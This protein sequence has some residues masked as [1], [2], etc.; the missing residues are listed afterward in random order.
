MYK[1][2]DIVKITYD[3]DDDDKF[4]FFEDT[5]IIK[6]VVTHISN[7]D[8]KSAILFYELAWPEAFEPAVNFGYTPFDFIW[9]EYDFTL[10]RPG[11]VISIVDSQELPNI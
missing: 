1:V 3:G 8:N 2:G 10:L 7:I 6:R 5:C 11:A 4:N 9:H